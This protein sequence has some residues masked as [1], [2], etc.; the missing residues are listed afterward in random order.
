MS[1]EY[2]D[3]ISGCVENIVFTS[4]ETGFTVASLKEPRKKD[5]TS[6]VGTLPLLQPGETLH[7]EGIWRHH[8]RHGKQFEVLTCKQ[9]APQDLL[10]I[11]KYLESGFI[12][13]IGPTYAK[14]IVEKFGLQTLRVIDETPKRLLEVEG[15]GEKR[16][17]L[18][19]KNWRDQKNIRHVMIFLQGH[20]IGPSLAQKIYKLY[21]DESIEKVKE[22]PYALAK[23]IFGVG[24]KT[25]DTIAK[26]LGFPPPLAIELQQES[27][28]FYGR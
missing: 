9:S 12:R 21:G 17:D 8:P 18:I 24:F 6:I 10:G 16:I 22:N 26:N 4:E 7:C 25:A 11:K 20:Q 19:E 13:G 27:N 1:E 5:L 3:Q 28:F 15:I 14:R 2:K 23:K